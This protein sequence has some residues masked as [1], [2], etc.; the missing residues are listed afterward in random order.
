MEICVKQGGKTLQEVLHH[1]TRFLNALFND[2]GLSI[3]GPWRFAFAGSK[4]DLEWHWIAYNLP[5]YYRCNFLCSACLASQVDPVL[6]YTKHYEGAEWRETMVSNTNFLNNLTHGK[7]KRAIPPLCMIIGWNAMLLL[8]DIMH[9]LYQGSGNDWISSSLHLLVRLNFYGGK[10]DDESLNKAHAA[11]RQWCKS[12]GIKECIPPFTPSRC[13]V[14]ALSN[15]SFGSMDG[16]AAHIKVLCMFV[17]HELTLA[18]SVIE[19]EELKRAAVCGWGLDTF[20]RTCQES[21]MIMTPDQANR[22]YRSGM[23]FLQNYCELAYQ[24]AHAT[25]QIFR[26]KYRPKLHYLEH[27]LIELRRNRFNPNYCSN[28][29]DEDYIGKIAKL[30]GADGYQKCSQ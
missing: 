28:F 16:K 10:D 14:Y 21:G 7:R 22:A 25:P 27:Q 8:W 12:Q 15:K 13:G 6:L 20:I 29:M 11:C 19:D 23:V 26:Y 3:A 5:N 1:F 18:T 4:G 24:A 9:I 17:S 2:D 30:A